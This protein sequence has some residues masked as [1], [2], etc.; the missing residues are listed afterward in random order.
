MTIFSGVSATN[1]RVRVLVAKNR[2]AIPFQAAEF[3]ML[4]DRGISKQADLLDL[5]TM[6]EIVTKEGA[7]Y[8]YG[9]NS[10]G[11]GRMNASE[12]L[13]QNQEIANEIENKVRQKY[14]RAAKKGKN[15]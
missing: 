9:K 7:F 15:K 13:R 1:S 6:H 8:S 5:A 3:D 14:D 12:Y 2:L 10:L 4:F 11:Q